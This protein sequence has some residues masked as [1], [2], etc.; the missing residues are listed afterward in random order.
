MTAIAFF[1]S[2][3]FYT[4]T[5]WTHVVKMKHLQY[6][7]QYNNCITLFLTLNDISAAPWFRLSVG[8]RLV[9]LECTLHTPHMGQWRYSSKL[10]W[11]TGICFLPNWNECTAVDSQLPGAHKAHLY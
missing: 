1:V 5:Y 6:L 3:N 9:Q 11:A 7:Y 4:E 8:L 2:S 10:W